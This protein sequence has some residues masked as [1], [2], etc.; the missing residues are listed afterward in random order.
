MALRIRDLTVSYG[1]QRVLHGLST[2]DLRRGEVTAV[3]GPNGAGKSSL[4]R[5]IA[6]ALRPGAGTITLDDNDLATLSRAARARATFHLGQDLAPRVALSVFDVVL[7]S[8]KSLAGD[9]GVR[10]RPADLAAVEAV[11]HELAIQGL[12]DRPVSDLSGGQRQLV[13]IAQ[14]LVRDPQVLLLDEPTSALDVRRQLEVLDLVTA[15]TRRRTIV[16]LAALHDLSLAARFADN[17]LVLDAGRIAAEGAPA[18]VLCR[19]CTADAYR[20][21]LGLHPSPLGHLMVDPSLPPSR[22]AS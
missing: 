11:L 12:A 16:T 17:L 6:G 22:P 5:C 9:F 1:R 7:L 14:A 2:G 20:V 8:R 18:D 15:L 4:F 3:V 21:V 13:G 19:S 10:A